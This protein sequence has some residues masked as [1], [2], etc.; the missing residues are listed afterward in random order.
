VGRGLLMRDI[1]P[2]DRVALMLPTGVD[3][4]VAFLVG[5]RRLKLGERTRPRHSVNM[6]QK[7]PAGQP[8]FSFD[9]H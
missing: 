4:F 6:T 5:K 3:F 1:V 7:T 2:E 9:Q 8:G